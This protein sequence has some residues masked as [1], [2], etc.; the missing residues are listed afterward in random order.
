[1]FLA[2][3]AVVAFFGICIGLGILAGH[4]EIEAEKREAQRKGD[5]KRA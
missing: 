5:R 4:L 1:M 3:V 2:L